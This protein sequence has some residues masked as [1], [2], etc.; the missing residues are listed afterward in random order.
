MRTALRNFEGFFRGAQGLTVSSLGIG[1][2]LGD[3]D[4]ATDRAYTDAARIA[5]RIRHQ[6]LRYGH[7]L[8]ESKIR[9]LAR[10]GL[11]AMLR[12]TSSSFARKR[13]F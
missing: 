13:D 2:Y 12:A 11:A 1:T 4:E 6:L 7:Q 9:A 3:P 8:S 5:F 10:R